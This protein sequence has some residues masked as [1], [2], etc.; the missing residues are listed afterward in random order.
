MKTLDRRTAPHHV[1]RCY[2]EDGRLLYVGASGD[3]WGRLATHRKTSWWAPQVAR[4]KA[5]YFPDGV[6]ARVEER[7]IIRDDLPRFNKTGKWV[8]RHRWTQDQWDDW[9]LTSA[10]LCTI[11]SPELLAH[12][13][14]YRRLWGC[15]PTTEFLM[16]MDELIEERDRVKAQFQI[17]HGGRSA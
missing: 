11:P 2:S 16:L 13:A 10:H 8:T 14:Q 6:T 7:R 17:L 5:A 9:L 1:Y 3:L 15:E 4:V 12:T